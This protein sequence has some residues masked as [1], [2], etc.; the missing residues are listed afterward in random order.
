MA[1]AVVGIIL[2]TSASDTQD[3]TS[4]ITGQGAAAIYDDECVYNGRTLGYIN[5]LTRGSAA[6]RSTFAAAHNAFADTLL[7]AND[8]FGSIR[9]ADD[10]LEESAYNADFNGNG[11]TDDIINTASSV[12][13]FDEGT[14]P[15][16]AAGNRNDSLIYLN[17]RTDAT[18]PIVGDWDHL[19]SSAANLVR[20]DNRIRLFVNSVDG[21]WGL[22]RV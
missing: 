2:A 18:T 4:D 16:I 14:V 22:S 10:E 11:N 15:T 3:A 17:S 12:A 8:V 21:C 1:G 7:T 9:L 6:T 20:L 19:A 5:G 13:F